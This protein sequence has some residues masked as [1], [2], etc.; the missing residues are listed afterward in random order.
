MPSNT[1]QPRF[2]SAARWLAAWGVIVGAGAPLPSFGRA[3]AL[4]GPAPIAAHV[5]RSWFDARTS[6]SIGPRPRL[7]SRASAAHSPTD[8]RALPDPTPNAPTPNAPTPNAPDADADAA[9]DILPQA[10]PDMPDLA[11]GPLAPTDPAR[12]LRAQVSRSTA[13]SDGGIAGDTPGLTDHNAADRIRSVTADGSDF[14]IT[15]I[16]L[17]WDA[18]RPG[19]VTLSLSGGVKAIHALVSSERPET[20]GGVHTTSIDHARGIIS[21]PVVGGGVAWRIT[22]AMTL[23]GTAHT[24]ALPTSGSYFDFNAQTG[25]R[26]RPNVGLYA[27][28]Q[29][30][31][32]DFTVDDLPAEVNAE[33]LYAR[34][35]IQF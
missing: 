19:P 31:L 12:T 15:D 11:V 28:Y 30:V 1:R 3:D 32:S 14:D 13:L 35:R 10:E 5:D 17:R 27:G 34:L 9:L 2:T 4:G 16:A 25:I 23:S 6:L 29:Y 21:V 18:L 33:G 26:L 22:E 24:R 20:I 8:A 7:P